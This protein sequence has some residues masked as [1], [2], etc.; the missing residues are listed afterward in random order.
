MGYDINNWNKIMNLKNAL[1]MAGCG[2]TDYLKYLD[3]WQINYSIHLAAGMTFAK[4]QAAHRLAINMIVD[5][6]QVTV[7]S[8]MAGKKVQGIAHC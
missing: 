3:I 2:M 8:Y 1:C 4:W 6:L 5:N 7:C